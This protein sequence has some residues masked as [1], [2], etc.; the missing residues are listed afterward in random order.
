MVRSAVFAKLKIPPIVLFFKAEL[1]YSVKKNVEALFT[2]TTAY[3]FADAHNKK[4]SRGNRFAVIVKAHIES[5]N[6]L[7]I[8]GNKN[9]FFEHF[10]GEVSFVLSLKVN[11]PFNRVLK[12]LSA[13]FKDF[14][15]LGISN[16]SK[17]V[18]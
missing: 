10:F 3:N 6:L 1:V 13:F 15:C 7:R 4:V 9:R 2:L 16:M 5:L 18:F 17:I 12:F 11:A 8:I 14:N